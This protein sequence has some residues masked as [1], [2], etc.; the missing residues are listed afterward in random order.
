MRPD[1]LAGSLAAVG[2]TLL[3][4]AAAGWILAR[5]IFPGGT[6]WRMER[7]G[8]GL[9]IGTLL[10]AANVPFALIFGLRPGIFSL[11]PLLAV[12]GA[13]AWRFALPKEGEPQRT[14]SKTRVPLL[15][16]LFLA[17]TALGVTVYA[18][19][20][21]AEP[22]W[23]ND[24]LAV[25]GLKGKTIFGEGSLPRRLFDWP[26]FEFSNPGYPL[27]LPLLYAGIAFLLGA[28]EDHTLA[29]L[30]PAWLVATLLILSGWLR[31]RGASLPVALAA[32]AL[33]AQFEPLY[34]AHLSGM[35]EVPLSFSFLLLGTSLS[36]AMDRTD[37]GAPRRLALASLLAAATKSEGLFLVAAAFF[38]ILIRAAARSAQGAGK[39]AAAL[40]FPAALSAALHRLAIGSHPVRGLDL[41]YLARPD[42]SARLWESLRLT[43]GLHVKPGWLAW[44]ALLALLLL[45]R[46][47]PHGDRLLVLAGACFAV[48]LFLPALCVFDP[49]WLVTWTQGRNLAALAPLAA[50][51][52]GARVALLDWRAIRPRRYEGESANRGAVLAPGGA[53]S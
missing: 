20:A 46:A 27:G 24:F 11:L 44:L 23:S 52:I 21:L 42:L 38:F 45:G 4:S 16:T 53:S 8:W 43:F 28:W 5:A 18:V 29:I 50:A 32:A 40:V 41:A 1:G 36:D 47:N 49:V 30:F 17:L 13:L 39:T 35:A 9:G 33:L 31:R 14:R 26:S 25:W 7:A 51:G 48:Y 19:R 12:A 34:S 22:M 6:G 2:G 37:P 15:G 3:A 10:I